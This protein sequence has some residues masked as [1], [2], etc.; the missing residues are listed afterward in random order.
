MVAVYTMSLYSPIGMIHAMAKSL[1]LRKVL[2]C[3]RP[4]LVPGHTS[5]LFWWWW[6]VMVVVEYLY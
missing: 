5:Y 2:D 1:V 6:T 3:Y 4:D